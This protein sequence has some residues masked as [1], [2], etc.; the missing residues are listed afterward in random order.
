MVPSAYVDMLSMD[1][2]RHVMLAPALEYVTAT[3]R[4]CT[5]RPRTDS[6][7]RNFGLF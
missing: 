6:A 1:N 7:P 2:V 3:D 5:V 4:A